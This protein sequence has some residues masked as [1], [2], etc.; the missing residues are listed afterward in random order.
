MSESR[1]RVGLFGLVLALLCLAARPAYASVADGHISTGENLL[2][3]VSKTNASDTQGK[4]Y[5]LDADVSIDTSTLATS[6]SR[7]SPSRTFAGTLDG[8]GHTI[9][10]V[11]A[12]DDKLSQPLF[13][14]VQGQ[15][16]P[17]AGRAQIKNLTL[18]FKGNAQGATLAGGITNTLIDG[19]SVN[20]ENVEPASI[21]G[22]SAASGLV[23]QVAG[24][25][26]TLDE[27][28]AFTKIA[29]VTVKGGR[30]GSDNSVLSA[31]MLMDNG[32][33]ATF[34]RDSNVAATEGTQSATVL[35]NVTVNAGNISAKGSSGQ[36][37]AAGLVRLC[38]GIGDCHVNV[39][40]N[41]TASN[42]NPGAS[43]YL[44]SSGLAY[45]CD[46][47]HNDEI[48]FTNTATSV[49]VKGSVSA[50]N[51]G[52]GITWANGLALYVGI[53]QTW[54]GT[55]V[56]ANAIEAKALSGFAVASGFS[57]DQNNYYRESFDTVCDGTKVKAGTIS[58]EGTN[59]IGLA[60]GFASMLKY[61]VTNSSVTADT[62]SAK[63]AQAG[64]AE[65][66]VADIEVD[67][68]SSTPFRNGAMCD[69]DAVTV[70]TIK[71][72]GPQDGSYVGG[73]S[74]NL[75]A[76]NNSNQI[77]NS[78]VQNCSVTITDG[79][80]ALVD[81]ESVPK[82]VGLFSATNSSGTKL[83]NNTVTLPQS[84]A[85]VVVLNGDDAGSYVRFTADEAD[86][87]AASTDWQ[88]GNQ[89]LFSDARGGGDV[90][91]AFDSSS[92]HGTLWR[93]PDPQFGGLTISCD[94]TGEGAQAS[95]EFTFTLTLDDATVSG[96]YGDLQFVDGV[97]TFTL[98]AGQSVTALKLPEGVGYKVSVVAPE[99]YTV[100]SSEGTE[101]TVEKDETAV[102]RFT[103][104]KEKQP[105]PK[106]VTPKPTTPDDGNGGNGGSG[107]GGAANG[108]GASGSKPTAGE[109]LPQTGDAASVAPLALVGVAVVTAGI[110]VARK[111]R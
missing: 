55:T 110:A 22:S 67:D 63:G 37:V 27:S 30:V 42:D 45:Q 68:Y 44:I 31:G 78:T 10:V 89:V 16:G 74:A 95:D 19:V 93:L 72:E 3:L 62:V 99:G 90:T 21:G 109:Q 94:A 76:E 52:G 1:W 9:T 39:T 47:K 103:F 102:V 65:G 61:P 12:A 5:T 49:D 64:Q 59:G 13:D 46:T 86:G 75:D 54:R 34:I 83:F 80:D 66:F 91:C 60:N 108:G 98:K 71:S 88:R 20:F 101:G 58:A 111:G 18:T 85:N 2:E 97:A 48:G 6:F 106:P 70:G 41:I 96:T 35:Y 4:T 28:R 77:G 15:S 84:Q 73:F 32:V 33:G 53:D 36:V 40:G 79:L 17:S 81:G 57:Y 50:Q 38:L 82:N 69:G 26:N 25:D 56:S 87:R 14:L 11:A 8:A 43:P 92:D 23:G 7:Y 107:N 100:A 51:A 104:N 29:N 24:G 105:D